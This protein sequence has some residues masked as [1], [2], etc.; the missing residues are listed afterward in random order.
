MEWEVRN[1]EVRWSVSPA[2]P[3]CGRRTKVSGEEPMLNISRLP[4]DTEKLTEA[5]ESTPVVQA[6]HIRVH[7]VHPV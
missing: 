4:K 6:G 7:V 2:S 3:Q 5:A 1:A